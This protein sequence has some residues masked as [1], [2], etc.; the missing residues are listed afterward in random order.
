M[1]II[2][3]DGGATT[4]RCVISDETG[5]IQGWGRGGPSDHLDSEEGQRRLGR[6]L[7][8]VLTSAAAGLG[9]G[10]LL[11]ASACLGMTGV[12]SQETFG[13]VERC[14]RSIVKCRLVRVCNDMEI[15]LA[16][17]AVLG[18]GLLIYAGTGSHAYAIDERGEVASAGGWGHIIDDAGAGYDIGRRALRAVFRAS[19][20]MASPTI[21]TERIREHWAKSSLA[22][23]RREVY[24]DDA[25]DRPRI[26]AI[27]EV[28]AQAAADGDV[29]AS[30]ILRESAEELALLGAAA[31][32]KLGKENTPFT[33]YPAGGIFRV[34]RPIFEPFATTLKKL[35]PEAL[36]KTAA[37]PPVIGALLL[38]MRQLDLAVTGTV[39]QRIRATLGGADA[40]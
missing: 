30:E 21:L 12:Y 5:C 31:L 35:A 26:A 25:R 8:E 20:G 34:G 39:V 9:Q 6:A 1:Y 40:L 17:A 15:A 37:F 7:E 16:G 23:V 4:S 14:F 19:D 27:A 18:P 10:P 28:V 38:A 36:L 22:E 29:V 2:G 24:K 11:C 32:R 3:V 33:V 13:I